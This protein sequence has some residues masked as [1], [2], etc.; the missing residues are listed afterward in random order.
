MKLGFTACLH[1]P[2]QRRLRLV[3]RLGPANVLAPVP[4]GPGCLGPGSLDV[5][6]GSVSYVAF[7]G[8]VR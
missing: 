5:Q 8:G 4:V 1:P 6:R 2:R 3:E 7:C